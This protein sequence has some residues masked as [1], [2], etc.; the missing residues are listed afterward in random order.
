MALDFR[1]FGGYFLLRLVVLL[2]IMPQM[3]FGGLFMNL[4][5]VPA[6][7]IWLKTISLFRLGFEAL[8]RWTETDVT[9]AESFVCRRTILTSRLWWLTNGKT[10]ACWIAAMARM[11]SAL[12]QMEKLYWR[13]TVL[14][15]MLVPWKHMEAQGLEGNMQLDDHWQAYF[16]AQVMQRPFCG[17]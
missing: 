17:C 16:S 6:G 1:C 9:M 2:N 14:M 10:T 15:L 5:S 4:N 13:A 12:R 7:F 11:S 3:L 8:N